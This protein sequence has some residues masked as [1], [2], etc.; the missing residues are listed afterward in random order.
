MRKLLIVSPHFPPVNAPDGHRA[1]LLAAGLRELGWEP[2]VLATLPDVWNQNIDPLLPCPADVEV[3]RIGLVPPG[4]TSWCGLRNL[5]WRALP[6]LFQ[7]GWNILNTSRF[8]VVVFSTTQFVCLVL[9]P[10]WKGLTG[11][12]FVVD[13]QD[14]WRT[15]FYDR[16]GAPPPP[17][18]GKFLFAKSVAALLEGPVF[19]RARGI[20][21]VTP[22][23]LDQCSARY[24]WF[25]RCRTVVLP[26]GV[27]PDDAALALDQIPTEPDRGPVC[28]GRIGDDMAESLESFLRAFANYRLAVPT[29]SASFVGTS[30]AR[31]GEAFT[32]VQ[33]IARASGLG[34][35]AVRE[36]QGRVGYM[37]ALARLQRAPLV[38]VLGSSD[39]DYMPSKL[40]VALRCARA[41]VV[42]A[43]ADSALGR[44][45]RRESPQCLATFETIGDWM[46][47]FAR[48]PMR[49]KPTPGAGLDAREMCAQFAGFL[50]RILAKK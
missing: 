30:Y 13:L 32:P 25:E 33:R 35:D 4:W 34:E 2:T 38:V 17:G 36:E 47:A 19:R 22:A 50:D 31:P 15:D 27:S 1:R 18:G 21:S 24:A 9:G 45:V 16:P 49:A 42:V 40:D 6:G 41:V 39:P 26:M 8:D 5:G 14:A 23:Y 46:A 11:V 37:V 28:F 12:P 48:E 20:V 10:I 7:S 43:V 3:H 29:A 44:R